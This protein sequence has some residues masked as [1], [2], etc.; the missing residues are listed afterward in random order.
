MLHH[1]NQWNFTDH[2]KTNIAQYFFITVE[3]TLWPL[4]P[5]LKLSL[6]V[7]R[8]PA[9]VSSSFFPPTMSKPGGRPHRLVRLPQCQP[10]HR[11]ALRG[12]AQV[13]TASENHQRAATYRY[14]HVMT[15]VNTMKLSAMC[16]YLVGL[17][18]RALKVT[19]CTVKARAGWRPAENTGV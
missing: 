13:L 7:Q 9:L 8:L 18:L 19:Y 5:P 14:V 2:K 1:I 4:C 17:E 12:A 3:V 15:S 11:H 16:F 6:E 10:L